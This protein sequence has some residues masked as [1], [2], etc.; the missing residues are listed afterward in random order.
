MEIVP[1]FANNLWAFRFSEE[2]E[3]EFQKLFDYWNDVEFLENFFEENKADLQCG[4][5]GT[6]S[7]EQAVKNTWKE[8][9]LFEQEMLELAGNSKKGEAPDL[10]KLF[11]PLDNASSGIVELSMSKAYG[12]CLPSWLRIYAIKVDLNTYIITGGAI[13]LTKTMNERN[14]LN[15]ELRKLD[16]CKRWLKGK[17]ICDQEGLFDTDE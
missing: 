11:R 17:G 9:E 16:R 7:V 8:A 5:W 2:D 13:K 14:H 10:D 4:F 12:Y 15:D 6:I 1:I 3:N